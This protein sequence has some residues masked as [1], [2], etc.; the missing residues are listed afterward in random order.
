MA[1]QVI[2]GE[3]G[4]GVDSRKSTAEE[5]EVEVEPSS[6]STPAAMLTAHSYSRHLNSALPQHSLK[7]CVKPAF[8][9]S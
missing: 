4:V 3:G 2:D 9:S 6:P 7:D 8:C 1:Q 5:L